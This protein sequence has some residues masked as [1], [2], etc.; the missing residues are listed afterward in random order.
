MRIHDYC[1]CTTVSSKA[2]TAL[3]EAGGRGTYR[4]AHPWLVA[5]ELVNSADAAG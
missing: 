4:D 5:G 2:I 1:I 3:L